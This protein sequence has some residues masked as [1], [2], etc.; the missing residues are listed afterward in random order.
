MPT[1]ILLRIAYLRLNHQHPRTSKLCVSPEYSGT[2]REQI[3]RHVWMNLGHESEVP[4]PGDYV[5]KALPTL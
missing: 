4:K 5:V 3:S 2:E 1:C